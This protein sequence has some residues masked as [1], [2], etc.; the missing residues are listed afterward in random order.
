MPT[1]RNF[2]ASARQEGR[3]NPQWQRNTGPHAQ[4]RLLPVR[5]GNRDA[6]DNVVALVK[7]AVSHAAMSP[8]DWLMTSMW[9]LNRCHQTVD[10]SR[11]HGYPLSIAKKRQEKHAL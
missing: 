7:F 8:N 4:E 1:A 5:S 2:S 3:Q 6:G 9:R 10:Q 11:C